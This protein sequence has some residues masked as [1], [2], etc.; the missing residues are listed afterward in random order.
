MAETVDYCFNTSWGESSPARRLAPIGC[1][2]LRA[3]VVLLAA[4]LALAGCA[5][6]VP[7]TAL[8]EYIVY[9][10]RG[11]HTMEV[12]RAPDAHRAAVRF[13]GQTLELARADSAAQE[14]YSN[15]GMALYLEG[16]R[17]M[18]ESSGVVTRGP[19]VAAQPLPSY[20][21]YR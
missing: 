2:A 3:A 17:A 10:C 15:G 14:K 1:R 11:D 5:P 13:D 21:R 9:K 4:T 7:M 19:C 16:E 6:G 12:A 8:P 18:L 20:Y